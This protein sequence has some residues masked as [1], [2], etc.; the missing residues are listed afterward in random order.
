V[1][2]DRLERARQLRGCPLPVNPVGDVVAYTDGSCENNGRFG[3][4]AGIG[5][6]FAENHPLNVSRRCIGRQTNNNAEIQAALYAVEIVK[7][8]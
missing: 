6:W 7:A 1:S 2:P 5:V 3:A 8:R 4:V